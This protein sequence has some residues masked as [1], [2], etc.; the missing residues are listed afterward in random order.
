[1]ESKIV[2]SEVVYNKGNDFSDAKE[3]FYHPVIIEIKDGEK[4]GALFSSTQ[5]T[6][7]IKLGE[8]KSS[9]HPVWHNLFSHLTKIDRYLLLKK[10]SWKF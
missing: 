4:I 10:K 8:L 5:I 3:L 1:M 9:N 2:M 7:A 6:D